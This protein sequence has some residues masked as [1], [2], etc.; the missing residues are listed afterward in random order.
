MTSQVEGLTRFD[1][2]RRSAVQLLL[3]VA[4]LLQGEY[5]LLCVLKE[6][7]RETGL[8][9]V[10]LHKS[11]FCRGDARFKHFLCVFIFVL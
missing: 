2:S 7:F 9:E 1:L 4:C 8:S 5:F 11:W 3:L 10:I 6:E